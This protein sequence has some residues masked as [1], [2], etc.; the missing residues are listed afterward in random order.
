MTMTSSASHHRDDVGHE[1]DRKREVGEQE[2]Q[3]EAHSSSKA[4]VD[5]ESVNEPD[6]VGHD[7]GGITQR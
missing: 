6:G 7:A 3:S 2:E 4:G 5:G 1:V